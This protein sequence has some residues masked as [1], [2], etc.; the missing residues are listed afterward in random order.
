MPVRRGK[1]SK[2]DIKAMIWKRDSTLRQ[3]SLRAGLCLDAA[4]KAL[5]QPIPAA[6]KAIAEFLNLSVHEL[7]PNWFD[8]HGNRI[9]TRHNQTLA[10]PMRSVNAKTA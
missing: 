1:F 6:N 10:Q 2:E 3:I 5:T 9:C 4:S 7:W 8:Q